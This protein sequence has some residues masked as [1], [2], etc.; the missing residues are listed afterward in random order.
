MSAEGQTKKLAGFILKEFPDKVK[1]G[2]G[3]GDIA[4][5]ILS[6]L[7]E[8]MENLMKDNEQLEIE[9]RG[10]KKELD[11]LKQKQN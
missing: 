6:N 11:D 10:L 4:I 9:N 1:Y 8:K 3:A 5:E 7:K 2:G